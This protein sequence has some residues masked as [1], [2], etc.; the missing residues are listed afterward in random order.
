[1]V[2]LNSSDNL[3]LDN[4]MITKRYGDIA[5]GHDSNSFDLMRH[6][7]AFFVLF[8]HHFAF[9]GLEEPLVFGVTKLGT[10]AVIVFFSISGYLITQSYIRT[11]RLAS[12]VKKRALRIFPALI[13]CSFVMT[14]FFCGIFGKLPAI[15]YLT[16]FEALKNLLM[17]PL[18]GAHATPAQINFFGENFIHEGA[19]NGSLWTLFFEL[20]D[21]A[22][23]VLFINNKKFPLLG[24]VIL[25][26]GST[27][28][29]V[30]ISNGMHGGYYI[31]RSTILT[32]PFSIGAILLLTKTYWFRKWISVALIATAIILI[33]LSNKAD[34]R[35]ILFFIAIPIL[36]I[37]IGTHVKE[38]IIKGRFDISYGIYIYAYPV[39]QIV[40][41]KTNLG[42][43]PS[44]IVSAIITISLAASSWVFV[45]SKFL[46]RKSRLHD[47]DRARA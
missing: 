6:A 32:I 47:N 26:L 33:L 3:Y 18:F 1:M 45:E 42:F 23:V 16:S 22:L 27:S 11:E 21:Y 15:E 13:I 14:I 43:W 5:A 44:M 29:Q 4:P 7:A 12:Y 37:I 9:Y 28:V 40:V 38:S 39:Q 36:T 41:N 31:D 24:M 10:F 17:F 25:L 20:F 34:E 19:L 8:S 2:V 35:S 30:M 46:K